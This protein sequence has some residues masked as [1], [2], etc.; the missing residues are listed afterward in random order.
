MKLIHT[1]DWH[2][3]Q[4]FMFRQRARE[5][6]RF[7]AWLKE[8]ICRQNAELLIVSGDIFDTA[9]PPSYALQMYYRFLAD[10]SH[11]TPCHTVVIISGNHDSAAVLNAPRQVLK[12][13]NVHVVASVSEKPEDDIIQ[14]LDPRSNPVAY[15]CAVPF[16]RDQDIRRSIPGESWE[17][18]NKAMITGIQSHYQLMA[19]TARNRMEQ[20]SHAGLPLI[21]TGHLFAS[22]G[23][24][25]DDD[26]IRQI[27]L[28][29]L[30]QFNL[31]PIAGLFDYM[32]L[33]HLHR[34]QTVSGLDHVRYSGS[35]IPLSFGES[36]HPKHVLG[37]EF[38]GASPNIEIEKI[39]IPCFQPLIRI[40]GTFEDVLN[41]MDTRK[42]TPENAQEENNETWA[43]ITIRGEWNPMMEETIR[44]H[45]EKQCIQIFIIKRQVDPNRYPASETDTPVDLDHFTC[46]DVFQK[47]LE[48][49]DHLSQEQIRK[50]GIAFDQ[51]EDMARQENNDTDR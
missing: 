10:L 37:V 19:R 20:N 39:Q 47:R 40:S 30:G 14:V 6:D 8:T 29:N 17:D 32:A 33:G 24:I 42:D 36:G 45:A 15:V 49:E 41:H 16:L 31:S 18:K 2:L 48:K 35:P 11:H 3:G 12:A 1:S 7:L 43:E 27:H 5:H 22:G 4:N 13:L 23:I 38:S 25:G 21:G 9:S 50:L 44:S 46:K 26:H 34:C 28:G 51:V